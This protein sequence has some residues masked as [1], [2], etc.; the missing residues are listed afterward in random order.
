MAEITLVAESGRATGSSSS[1]RLRSEGRI[2]AVVYGHGIDPISVSVDA[3][4]LRTALSGEAGSRALLSLQIGGEAHLAMARQ[5]QRHPVRHTVTHIDFQVVRHDEIISAEV[6]VH[7]TG[8]A[9][10]V[11]RADGLIEHELQAL[12][13][14]STPGGLPSS[15]EVD[16][17]A[18]SIGDSIRASDLP[19]PEGVELDTDPDT[20]VVSA[21]AGLVVVE[22]APEAAEEPEEGAAEAAAEASEE[23]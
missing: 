17:S 18:L 5:L 16:I 22:E 14:R 4:E 13:V 9:I 11:N 10:E 2:P 6:P 7:L 23:G 8:E 19:L 20:V 15:F 1:R 12:P 3:R 21:R